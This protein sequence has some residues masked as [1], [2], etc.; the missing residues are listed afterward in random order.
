MHAVAESHWVI[1]LQQ[2]NHFLN[3]APADLGFRKQNKEP[4]NPWAPV[5]NQITSR[6]L[7]VIFQWTVFHSDLW[8]CSNFTVALCLGMTRKRFGELIWK[9]LTTPSSGGETE[10]EMLSCSPWNPVTGHVGIIQ[11]CARGG[12]GCT[13]GDTLPSRWSVPGTSFLREIPCHE[14]VSI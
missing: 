4:K 2:L 9:L 12:S 7:F 14:P 3:W 6:N 8:I 1:S 13:V 10:R 11:I 5:F